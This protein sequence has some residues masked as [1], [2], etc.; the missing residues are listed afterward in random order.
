MSLPG[1]RTY[2]FFFIF[3]SPCQD[4]ERIRYLSNLGQDP[5]RRSLARFQ[6]H[7]QN[8]DS[9]QKVSILAFTLAAQMSSDQSLKF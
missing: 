2:K 9:F 6:A 3:F 5:F 1:F 4:G 8:Q 7:V